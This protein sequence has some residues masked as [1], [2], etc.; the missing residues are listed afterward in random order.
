[1]DKIG[2]TSVRIQL[3]VRNISMVGVG[4]TA[5]KEGTILPIIDIYLRM[6]FIQ[7]VA[8]TLGIAIAQDQGIKTS[9]FINDHTMIECH[10][11]MG[12]AA[13]VAAVASSPTNMICPRSDLA[14]ACQIIREMAVAI[15]TQG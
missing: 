1:M 10:I 3:S 4:T 8:K 7:Q 15:Q 9:R 6:F 12:S 2:D 5:I 13:E 11:S 14:A